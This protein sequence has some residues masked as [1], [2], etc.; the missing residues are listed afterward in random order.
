VDL[1][2]MCAPVDARDSLGVAVAH[3]TVL[4][5]STRLGLGGDTSDE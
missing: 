4:V 1:F 2:N 5:V 3:H